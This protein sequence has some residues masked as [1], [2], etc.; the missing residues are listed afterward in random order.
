M[1]SPMK[2]ISLKYDEYLGQEL[3]WKLDPIRFKN[4]NLVVGRNST[5][6]SR[7][8]SIVTNF[9]RYFTG[10]R[11]MP[12]SGNYAVEFEHQ[13]R[14]Y[15]FECSMSDSE[16]ISERLTVD[17]VLKIERGAG[18][19][20]RIFAE[21]LS[22][23]SFLPFRSPPTDWAVVAKRDSLQ[24]SFLEP[25]FVWA[26]GV[27]FFPFGSHFGKEMLFT[28]N[29]MAP[30]PDELD[31]NLAVP[32]FRK[33]KAEFGD[34]FIE[35][36]KRDLARLDYP[37]EE[38]DISPPVTL[39]IPGAPPISTLYVREQGMRA[40]VD[41]WS[42]STGMYRVVALLIHIVYA[43][44]KAQPSCVV[45]DD[46]GEGLDYERSC[47]L[48]DLIREKCALANIQ[49]LLSTND[50]FVMNSV[51]LDEWCFLQRTGQHVR[52]LTKEN[53]QELFE[54]FRFTGLSNFSFFE[55]NS[56]PREGRSDA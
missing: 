3:E 21:E 40:R 23:G 44:L 2:L 16:L 53:S 38:I 17:D 37:V 48:I 39:R 12:L 51:P 11:S 5:G 43:Q 13:Q 14:R 54:E 27:R 28:Q 50:R 30:P 22:G 8:L 49:L 56:S 10:H 35:I 46:I 32:I 26:Q 15:L 47:Q 18:G 7:L 25:L 52:A 55:E 41:Q 45:I 4:C 20:G 29:P 1:F 34:E 6:K 24:H 33:A 36:I 19:E 9:A 42:M 31:F